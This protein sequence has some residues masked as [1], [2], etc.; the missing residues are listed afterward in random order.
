M[1]TKTKIE[2]QLQNKK[3]SYLRE[4]IVTAKKN[5]KWKEIAGILSGPRKNRKNLNLGELEKLSEKENS[6][7]VSGKILSEGEV[8][9]KMKL[10]A[11]K[12]SKKAREKL[13]KS[14]CEIS[15]ILE[16]IKKNPSAKGIKILK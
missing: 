3:D 4:V 15:D 2:K 6:I 7:L 9:K 11:F 16:E 12:F 1:K 10:V 5:E 8:K 14:G 13:L